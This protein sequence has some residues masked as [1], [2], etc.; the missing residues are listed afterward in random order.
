METIHKDADVSVNFEDFRK[1]Y[2]TTTA[3]KYSFFFFDK[4][5][6]SFRQNFDQQFKLRE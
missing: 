5:T 3:Q 1:M 6:N 2:K 4:G